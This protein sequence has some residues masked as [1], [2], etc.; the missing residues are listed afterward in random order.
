MELWVD[1]EEGPSRRDVEV[2]RNIPINLLSGIGE[3]TRE[4]ILGDGVAG[5][6]GETPLT[7][8]GDVVGVFA[9]GL[10]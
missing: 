4:T 9:Y 10:K 2:G 6:I 3:S 1:T 5:C 7:I 8:F